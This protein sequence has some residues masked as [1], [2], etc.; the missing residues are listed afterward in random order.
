M[1]RYETASYNCTW[2]YADSNY[3]I[4]KIEQHSTES[5]TMR[6]A[7]GCSTNHILICIVFYL[8]FLTERKT[9]TI[10]Q[11]MCDQAKVDESVFHSKELAH[12][13]F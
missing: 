6:N 11:N 13:E 3:L 12:F 8:L 9:I 10:L 2:C 1:K 4:Q 7:Y 5:S